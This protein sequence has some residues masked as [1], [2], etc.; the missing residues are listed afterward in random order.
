MPKGV[1]VRKPKNQPVHPV[2]EAARTA[3]EL[4]AR[5][6][7]VKDELRP[8]DYKPTH[9]HT[10]RLSIMEQI[11]AR[12]Q[13]DRE[14]EIAAQHE[15]IDTSAEDTYREEHNEETTETPEATVETKPEI[16]PEAPKK[17]LKGIVD[18][19]EKEFDEDEVLKAGLA[20]LQ[21]QTAADERLEEAK[22]LLEEARSHKQISQPS[23]A[24]SSPDVD[25]PRQP[26]LDAAAIAKSI[27]YGNDEEGQKAVEMLLGQVKEAN[28]L[29]KKL[30]GFDPDQIFQYVNNMTDEREIYNEAKRK[31]QSSPEQ[32]GYADIWDDTQLRK[33]AFDKENE[34]RSKGDKRPYWEL[35]KAIGDEV[36][37]WRDSLVQKHTPKTLENREEKKREAVVVKGASVKAVVPESK[38]PSREEVL[39]QMRQARNQHAIN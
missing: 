25:S 12:A 15:N 23:G 37:T 24:P 1:Y 30:K 14:A 31:F 2:V 19:V 13:N 21:K 4:S 26:E 17:K 28:Q 9:A 29:L 34:L 20:T 8:S 16:T 6:P 27:M 33:M 10:E 35:F 36:R 18:G 39:N 5:L 22:R 38:P 11:A 3:S 7:E 32:G